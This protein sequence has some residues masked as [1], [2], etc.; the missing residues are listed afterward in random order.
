MTGTLRAVAVPVVARMLREAF[1]GP[2]GPW[3]YFT[4][5]APGVGVFTTLNG[6]TAAQ[7]SE[8]GGPSHSTI[9]G[10]V[11]HVCTSISLS[12]KEFEGEPAPRDRN[13]AWPVSTVD[14]AEWKALRARLRDEYHGLLRAVE[15]R[16]L[17]DEDTLGMAMGAVAHT[18]YH[19]GAIRQ[20]LRAP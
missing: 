2:P 3:T 15:T 19:L 6:L 9:A 14:D 13:K 10:H 7:A 1:D 11:D 18:A 4:E 5:A 16:P 12:R 20:R 17:W 8:P